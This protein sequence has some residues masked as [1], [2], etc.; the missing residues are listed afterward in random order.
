MRES[1]TE[2]TKKTSDDDG[3][4]PAALWMWPI[5]LCCS[6]GRRV[7]KPLDPATVTDVLGQ[8]AARAEFH[9]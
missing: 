7:L 3:V 1:L 5:L 8:I 6:R 9:D 2:L 4:E